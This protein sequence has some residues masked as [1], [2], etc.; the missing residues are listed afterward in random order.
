MIK[1]KYSLHFC[2]PNLAVCYEKLGIEAE[3]K[4]NQAVEMVKRYLPLQ[5]VHFLLKLDP[6]GV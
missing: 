2:G 6:G 5:N 3:M 4:N 1:G